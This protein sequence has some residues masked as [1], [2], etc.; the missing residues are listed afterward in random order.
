MRVKIALHNGET[1][2]QVI[3]G[4]DGTTVKADGTRIKWDGG[5]ICA[6]FFVVPDDVRVS[7]GDPVEEIR[8]KDITKNLSGDGLY[9]ELLRR[10]ERLEGG[11]EG[12]ES[13]NHNP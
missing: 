8:E 6:P 1:V 9:L 2:G 7:P 10:I 4:V 12:S 5:D 13:G 11:E 3:N